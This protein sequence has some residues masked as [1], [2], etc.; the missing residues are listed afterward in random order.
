[1]ASITMWKRGRR[2]CQLVVDREDDRPYA[3]R[4]RD[5]VSVLR[6]ERMHSADQAILVSQI[7][8]IEEVESLYG[9]VPPV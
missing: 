3:L 8:H 4:I 1:M 2:V 5:D 7:W 9:A 6:A